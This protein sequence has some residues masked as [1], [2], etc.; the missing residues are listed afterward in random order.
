MKKTYYVNDEII[1]K[2]IDNTDRTTALQQKVKELAAS[3]T[4]WHSHA[5][6]QHCY[7]VDTDDP[8]VHVFFG[9]LAVGRIDAA[10]AV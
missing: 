9:L 4:Y 1:D 6:L 3:Y 8:T 10:L 2:I 5:A 7:Y